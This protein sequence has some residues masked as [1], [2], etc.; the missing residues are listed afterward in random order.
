MMAKSDS[1]AD[2]E[3][4]RLLVVAN[5]LPLTVSR[6]ADGGRKFSI[7]S[8]GLVSALLG[9]RARLPFLWIGWLGEEVPEAEQD[10]VRAQLLTD[11]SCLPVFLG[12]ALAESY[13]N[14]CSNDVL[15]PLF[16]STDP[17]GGGGG[18][19]FLGSAP[20]GAA[21]SFSRPLWEAYLEANAAFAAVL[22]ECYRPGDAVWVHDYHLMALPEM[23][24]T[25]LP[26]SP[27][28]VLAWFLH[29]ALCPPEI[30]A[31]LPVAPD[32]VRSLLNCDLVGFHTPD[33]ARSFSAAAPRVLPGVAA[34]PGRLSFVGHD[35]RVIVQPIGIDPGVFL[36][37]QGKPAFEARLAALGAHFGSSGP[38]CTRR[39]VI[40]AVD[41]LDPI[42]GVPHR[43]LGFEA[44]LSSHPSWRGRVSL[45]QVAVP[46]RI[47][48]PAY[49][50]LAA[51]C[52]T[53]VGRIN[54][55]F[56]SLDWAPIH[57]LFR[58]VDA[59]ELTALYSIADA[60]LITSLSDGMNL[61]AFEFVACTGS[62]N[63][64]RPHPGVLVLSEFVGAAASLPG[65]VRVNPWSALDVARGIES[66]LTMEPEEAGRRHALMHAYVVGHTSQAWAEGFVAAMGAAGER[67]ATFGSRLPSV[68]SLPPLPMDEL[69]TVFH[70]STPSPL[71]VLQLEALLTLGRLNGRVC[72]AL[73]ALAHTAR[74]ILV[75]EQGAGEVEELITS[76]LGSAC[77]VVAEGGALVRPKGGAD[78][79][80]QVPCSTLARGPTPR[81]AATP[82]APPG[83]P[84]HGIRTMRFFPSPSS[85][86][87][88]STGPLHPVVA[89]AGWLAT[90]PGVRGA[91]LPA[92]VSQSREKG[93][94][95]HHR[96]ST[97]ADLPP[98]ESTKPGAPALPVP[99]SGG[100]GPDWKE[101]LR[102]L[103]HH[104][105][106]MAPG[107]LL[108]E[109]VNSLGVRAGPEA[110]PAQAAWAVGELLR[111][112]QSASS[113][114]PLTVAVAG[115]GSPALIVRVRG[116]DWAAAFRLL[117]RLHGAD[118]PSLILALVGSSVP[119]HDLTSLGDGVRTF[120]ACTDA[121]GGKGHAL[122][123]GVEGIAALLASL[124]AAPAAGGAHTDVSPDGG[125]LPVSGA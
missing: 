80:Q 44:F 49:Q 58:S 117:R 60:C 82:R 6:D 59:V 48:V 94:G 7:S 55:R 116:A 43:L 30:F 67:A 86:G 20:G 100:P 88:A 28:P 71:L 99:C 63:A 41:R 124:T 22:T 12:A 3:A 91:L 24:R 98:T 77:A 50:Q 87:S 95:E 118:P 108:E 113:T 18:P 14:G 4:P 27:R 19:P 125:G 105:T 83:T 26:P 42:K 25:R 96:L 61:C 17:L 2:A 52:Q 29:T 1:D 115:S 89:P 56:G 74:I 45:V 107:L 10:V 13:Y 103:L 68:P 53:L 11:H 37:T 9:V 54:A 36:A 33:Y 70:H 81:G 92:A 85:S 15:W 32:L 76:P 38:P 120:L 35:T 112:L 101:E 97:L 122:V 123:G 57:Y 119:R 73:L 90:A 110:D 106:V 39:K 23:L 79:G 21:A 78:G 65:A 69:V 31:V 72:A 47:D 5:R 84:R 121:E 114:T 8:G 66:A 64:Y 46:S 51:A 111:A 104:F 40:F 93:D 16:H 75:S 109:G 102:P 34:S 62:C